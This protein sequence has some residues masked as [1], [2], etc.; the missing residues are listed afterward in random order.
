MAPA[1]TRI[2]TPTATLPNTTSRRTGLGL[3]VALVALL[4][5]AGIFAAVREPAQLDPAS[6]SGVVQQ[7]VQAVMDGDN[8]RAADFLS[9]NTECSAGDLDRTWIDPASRI[10]L[11]HSETSGDRAHVRI[12]INVPTGDLLKNTWTE[13]RTIRLERVGSTW[14]ITGVP[15]PLY[16]CGVWLK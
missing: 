6:P 15:W 13:E 10:D 11:L 8:D 7:Y 16:E 14:L 1:Q 2:V 5:I 9:A 3:G 12:A 4:V